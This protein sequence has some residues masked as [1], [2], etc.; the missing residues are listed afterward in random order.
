MNFN[1]GGLSNFAS[2]SSDDDEAQLMADLEAIDAE[3]K[4]IITQ[5]VIN[6]DRDSADHRLFNDY[7][8]ENPRYNDLM[9]RQ[10]FRMGISF[11]LRIVNDVEARDNFFVQRRDSVGRLGLSAL[12]KIIAVFR[13]LVYGLPAD[14]TDEYIKIGESTTIESLKRYYHVVVEEFADEYLRS[15][16]ATDFARLLHITKIVVF[17]E[18]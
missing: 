11:F 8:T 3:E 9:F 5:H 2:S 13:M 12:Q 18:C 17:Q 4:T 1:I 14:A 10:C 6:R 16:T 15:P 7:F